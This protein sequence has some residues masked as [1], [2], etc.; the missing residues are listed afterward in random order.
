MRAVKAVGRE[1]FDLLVLLAITALYSLFWMLISLIDPI[2]EFFHGF[3]T[4]PL[5]EALVSLPLLVLSGLLWRAYRLWRRA[6]ERQGALEGIITLQPMLGYSD[7]LLA[8]TESFD[9]K[10]VSRLQRRRGRR[11]RRSC[12]ERCAF[13]WWRTSPRSGS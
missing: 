5:A 12:R 11:A 6:D 10:T 3:T 9:D 4:W 1:F 2:H 13:S 7:L 8:Q